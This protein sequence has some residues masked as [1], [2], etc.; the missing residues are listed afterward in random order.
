MGLHKALAIFSAELTAVRSG[1]A[2]LALNLVDQ[3]IAEL[4]THACLNVPDQSR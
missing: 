3:R 2:E 1:I 4:L